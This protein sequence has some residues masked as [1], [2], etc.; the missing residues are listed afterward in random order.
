MPLTCVP[1]VTDVTGSIV[2]VAVMLFIMFAGATAAVSN[3]IFS[4]FLP[5]DNSHTASAA[6]AARHYHQCLFL[7]HIY[8]L[9]ILLLLNVSRLIEF[10]HVEVEYREILALQF[11]LLRLQKIRLARHQFYGVLQTLL[12]L[13]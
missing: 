7:I 4:S 8:S 2:P 6:I 12:E 5:P 1:T 13:L 10:K 9:I 11:V 3:V